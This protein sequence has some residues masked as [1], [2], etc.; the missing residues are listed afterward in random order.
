LAIT[1]SITTGLLFITTCRGLG[2]VFRLP[3][4][5]QRDDLGQPASDL[6]AVHARVE[7]LHLHR[8]VAADHAGDEVVD[9]GGAAEIL[10]RLGNA[11]EH[12][13]SFSVAVSFLAWFFRGGR[14][15]FRSQVGVRSIEESSR[16]LRA[17]PLPERDL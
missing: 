9:L 17:L 14:F 5:G 16:G 12:M 1:T 7:L 8:G 10:K 2:L 4:S 13:L 11:H 15:M 6:R 3:E